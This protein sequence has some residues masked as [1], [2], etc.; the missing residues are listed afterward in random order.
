MA[1]NG[2][3]SWSKKKKKKKNGR[4]EERGSKKE[5]NGRGKMA[6]TRTTQHTS[7]PEY[8][9]GADVSLRRFLPV[10]SFFFV[11]FFCFYPFIHHLIAGEEK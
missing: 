10:D 11:L 8:P 5:A 7:T 2:V 4:E 1:E 9:C 3:A 6:S